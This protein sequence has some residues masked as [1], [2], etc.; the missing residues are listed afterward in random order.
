MPMVNLEA[1]A[2]GI[3]LAVFRTGG[4]PEVVDET[5]CRVVEQGN[6]DALAN[7]V[8]ELAP[9]KKQL[10]AHCLQQAQRFDSNNCYGQYLHLYKELTA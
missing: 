9:Q 3:P 10:L 4:C 1:L 8:M 5:C 2:C 6:A 7:A